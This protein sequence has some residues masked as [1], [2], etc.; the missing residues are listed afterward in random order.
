[1]GAALALREDGTPPP[2]LDPASYFIRP[3][4]VLL[5]KEAQWAEEAKKQL[6]ATY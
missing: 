2:G 1:M 4:S 6:V 3:A 5:P